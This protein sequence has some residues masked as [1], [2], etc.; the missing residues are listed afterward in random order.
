MQS[1]QHSACHAAGPHGGRPHP[2]SFWGNTSTAKAGKVAWQEGVPSLLGVLALA[3]RE[4]GGA[5]R[6][7]LFDTLVSIRYLVCIFPGADYITA[8]VDKHLESEQRGN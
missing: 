3:G 6:G 8:C 1:P 4:E 5:G 2:G 7:H